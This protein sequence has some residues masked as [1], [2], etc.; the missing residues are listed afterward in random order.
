MKQMIQSIL[1]KQ[2]T[3]EN[4]VLLIQEMI[5]LLPLGMVV[6]S[7]TSFSA[8]RKFYE[9]IEQAEPFNTIDEY[10]EKCFHDYILQK[11]FSTLLSE[12]H[13]FTR[14]YAVKTPS[15]QEY[16]IENSTFQLIDEEQHFYYVTT[17]IDRTEENRLNT[18]LEE[19]TDRFHVLESLTDDYL[20]EYDF[21]N[22]TLHFSE[23]WKPDGINTDYPHA[24]KWLQLHEIIHPED[25][26]LLFDAMNTPRVSKEA[27]TFEFRAKFLRNSYTWYRICYKLI[28]SKQTNTL[29]AIGKINNINLERMALSSPLPE[30]V[31]AKT[32][33]LI[34]AYM[35][36]RANQILSEESQENICALMLLQ[37]DDFA[38]FK[39]ATGDLYSSRVECIIA[40]KLKNSFR[41]TDLIG[42]SRD[43]CYII[44]LR[45]VPEDIVSIRA[46]NVLEAFKDIAVDSTKSDKFSCSIG[47]SIAPLDGESYM[48]LF[49]KADSA[50]YLSKA[51]GGNT[52][53][54]YNT[55]V[56]NRQKNS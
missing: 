22:D 19:D 52:Y 33:L 1:D 56:D 16:Y 36:E 26:T 2:T 21:A 31:D 29:R 39:K 4:K 7:G 40:Q 5:D 35:Q 46:N 3:L 24:R 27:R 28:R 50:M 30:G 6:I 13:S 20:F 43:G 51:R 11:Q 44:F 42:Y 32:G 45:S 55:I 41:N 18:K 9:L 48:E 54:Y 25:L 17:L 47:I 10:H 8:N 23:R 37:L 53:S 38:E 15:E 49:L 12:N 14:F 34:P